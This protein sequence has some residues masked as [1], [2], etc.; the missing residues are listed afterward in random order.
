MA[1]VGTVNVEGLDKV[2]ADLRR[3]GASVD[4]M[5]SVG[6]AAARLV[7]A[8]AKRRVPRGPTGRLGGSLDSSATATAAFVEVGSPTIKYTGVIHFGWSTRGLGHGRSKVELLGALSGKGFTD[9]TL[10]KA[11][12]LSKV[13][14]RGGSVK[15]AVRG[16]PIRPNPFLYNAVDARVGDVTGKFDKHLD[17]IARAFNT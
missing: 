4:D 13:R 6:L 8:E 5:R 14:R 11:A 10:R 2:R 9:K 7:E 16:G 3:A 12:R 15:G 17:A 1:R